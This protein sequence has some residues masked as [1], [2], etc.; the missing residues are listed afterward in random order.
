MFKLGFVLQVGRGAHDRPGME[1]RAI[2]GTQR[3][4][5]YGRD[6]EM[7]N[8]RWK[9]FGAV[10]FLLLAWAVLIAGC[11]GGVGKERT[12]SVPM[13]S[14]AQ[15]KTQPVVIAPGQPE[16]ETVVDDKGKVELVPTPSGYA[17]RRL[18]ET[19]ETTS[20]KHLAKDAGSGTD[21]LSAEQEPSSVSS[22]RKAAKGPAMGSPLPPKGEGVADA[23]QKIVLNFDDA[24][25]YEVIKTIAELL[26]INYIVDPGIKGR[27]TIQTAGGF[28]KKDLFP[29][30][31][32]ILE[33]NNLT[34]FQEGSLYKIVPMKD[35]SRMPIRSR[36]TADSRD[37]PISE[38]VMIQIIP[39]RYISSQEITKLL[40]P[41]VSEGGV[42]VS[43][44]GSNTLVVVDKGA[45]I[46]KILRLVAAFDVNVFDRVHYRFY[47]LRY[48]D[49]E[50]VAK[51]LADFVAV[52]GDPTA[53]VKF[54]AVT[55]L[56]SLLAM[57]THAKIFE[58]LD[59][60]VRQ[61]DVVTD[62]AEPR[63]HVYFVKNG[64]AKDLA[65]LLGEVFLKKQEKTQKKET[66]KRSSSTGI[67]GNPFSQSRIAEKKAEEKAKAEA[68]E[69]PA[70]SKQPGAEVAEEGT[71]TVRSEI[72]ITPDEIRNALIIE[73]TPPDYR[74]V[75][76]ILKQ[77]DV[78]PRQVLI[79][80][81]IAE[82]THESGRELGMEWALGKGAAAGTAS[83]LAQIGSAGLTYS[84][85][86]TDKWYA[87][88]TALASKGLVNVIS[89][90]HVLASDN[91]EAKIDVSREIP[92]ASGTTTIASSTV[93]GETTIEYRDTGVILS[94]T[95]H[96][97]DRGLVTM[98]IS[99]EVSDLDK[100]VNVAGEN[101]P[102]FY[103]RTVT[104]TLT[105][106]HGQTIAIGGLIKDKEIENISGVPCLI[107]IPV[108]RYLFGHDSKET[109]KVELIVLLTPR[110]VANLDD[111]DAVT[112]EFKQKV[113]NV[114]KRFYK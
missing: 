106:K 3:Q 61:I 88:L 10:R 96:I 19:G 14:T 67:A 72:K 9:V 82:I 25:L 104:T 34:A 21:G 109:E 66:S 91:K 52:S 84:I 114:I 35:A 76:D 81:T 100:D 107:D 59:D 7:M 113:R 16:K 27:V 38:R 41:F 12:P 63:I 31:F 6:K 30:F 36:T 95:P 77:L 54:V 101:Y 71:G 39:L 17:T 57:S 83:F 44:K 50:E 64:E 65:E 1:D 112:E 18:D 79:E 46:M 86:V 49:A 29:V 42:I 47:R 110:V 89:S 90:P 68:R 5:F 2:R 37:L 74:I 60:I 93:V 43:D 11:G 92:V 24:D 73:A 28:R 51:L 33:A 105:V 108:V 48:L 26:K 97:N 103:K 4:K 20:P 62:E 15:K 40:T 80:A 87:E 111:V 99:E 85:G 55:R 23:D 94:V 98:D 45:N 70:A 56:N 69:Q 102:S 78:L 8:I 58:K 22:S 13:T 53:P 75:E 32:Q